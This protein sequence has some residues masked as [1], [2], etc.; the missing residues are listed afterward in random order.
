MKEENE[1][2]SRR[3]NFKTNQLRAVAK[4]IV[5]DWAVYV[6]DSDIGCRTSPPA[7]IAWLYARVEL[8]PS[9]ELWIWLQTHVACSNVCDDISPLGHLHRGSLL[10]MCSLRG[11]IYIARVGWG[12]VFV[13]EKGTFLL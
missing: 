11:N 7:Y 2:G 8:S 12:E 5:P 13:Y 6:V 1:R 4:F 9:Q 3:Q 10:L